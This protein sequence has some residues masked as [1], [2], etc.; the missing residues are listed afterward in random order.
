MNSFT[1]LIGQSQAVELLQ[2]AVKL[3]RIAPAY[4][5]FGA[6]GIGKSIAAKI[7]VQLLLSQEVSENK[8]DFLF[9]RIQNRNHPDLLWIEPTYLE[10]GELITNQEALAKG[11]KR[12]NPPQIR[13]EQIRFISEFLSRP[14]LEAQRLIVVIESAQTLGEAAANALLKT[15]EEPG[16][17]TI[18]MMAVNPDSLLPTLVSRCQSVPFLRLSNSNLERILVQQDYQEIL[19]HPEI[20]ALA[21]GSPGN[22]IAAW[23]QWQAISPEVRQQL[24]KPPTDA[25]QALHL[26]RIIEQLDTPAQIWLIDYLQYYYWQAQLKPEL[27]KQWEKARQYLFGYVQPRLVWEWVFLQLANQN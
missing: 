15:L 20:L 7:F 11:L 8:Q 10:K 17:A 1:D 14:A 16:Q 5:F 13:I 21:Q 2:R 4:L 24:K 27:V 18:I 3:N 6:D 26:A 19:E 12:K 23:Q 9:K 22:A 25:L